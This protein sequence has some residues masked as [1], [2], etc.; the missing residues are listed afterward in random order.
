MNKPQLSEEYKYN[1]Y[2]T[3]KFGAEV[4]ISDSVPEKITHFEKTAFSL[5]IYVL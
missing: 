4:E 5:K 1:T 2:I 3:V